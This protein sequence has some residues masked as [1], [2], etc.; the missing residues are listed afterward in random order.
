MKR[1]GN[2]TRWVD[3]VAV[4]VVII[5]TVLIVGDCRE[6]AASLALTKLSDL[7]QA[8]DPIVRGRVVRSELNVPHGGTA[9]V[10][11]EQVY[12]GQIGSKTFSIVWGKDSEDQNLDTVGQERLFFLGRASDGTFHGKHYGRSYW[13]LVRDAESDSKVTPYLGRMKYLELD[14]P[15]LTVTARLYFQEGP[16]EATPVFVESISLDRLI[17][18]FA[19][20]KGSK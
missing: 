16:S 5:S 4:L 6:T 13:P 3:V 19:K 11:V 8:S 9:T 14:I 12:R 20:A 17:P 2:G 1:V 10:Q 15:G 7:I 18:L